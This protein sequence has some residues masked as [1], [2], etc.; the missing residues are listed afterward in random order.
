MPLHLTTFQ[1]GHSS[2]PGALRIG[3]TRRPPRGV[4]KHRWQKD[5]YFDVWFPVVAPSAELLEKHRPMPDSDP[6]VWARFFAAYRRELLKPPA[7]HAVALL[8]AL[9]GQTPIAIGCYCAD[10]SRCH[11]SVLR[12]EISRAARS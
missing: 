8:A 9:A 10:A 12:E 2:E 4:P 1:I 5:G 7:S 6:K 3:A 11:R